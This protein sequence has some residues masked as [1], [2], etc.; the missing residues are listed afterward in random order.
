MTDIARALLEQQ[1][2]HHKDEL[3]RLY[4]Q[5]ADTEATKTRLIEQ[6]V[7]A[8]EEQDRLRVEGE[9][10]AAQNAQLRAELDAKDAYIASIQGG[11]HVVRLE[12]AIRERATDEPV[13]VNLPPG[14]PTRLA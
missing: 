9:K 10:L 7:A 5:L 4:R 1:I 8:D 11:A 6:L 13:A 12:D 2:A 3:T 14:L